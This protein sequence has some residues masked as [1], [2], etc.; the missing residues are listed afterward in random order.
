M[1]Q[2]LRLVFLSFDLLINY[3]YPYTHRSNRRNEIINVKVFQRAKICNHSIRQ[4]KYRAGSESSYQIESAVTERIVFIRPKYFFLAF[5][6][7]NH[8]GKPRHDQDIGSHN[9]PVFLYPEQRGK[10]SAVRLL[11]IVHHN[12]P[13]STYNVN[14]LHRCSTASSHL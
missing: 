6:L 12:M 13:F 1:V 7:G 3:G 5:F 14:I 9:P 11:I 2:F 8:R 10:E 4:S